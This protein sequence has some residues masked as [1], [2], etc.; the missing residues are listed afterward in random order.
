MTEPPK[1]GPQ[2]GAVMRS[3]WVSAGCV[4]LALGA[5][6]VVLPLLPTTPLVLLAAFCFARGSPR[7]R[8]RLTRSRVFGPIIADWEAHGAIAPRYKAMA[9]GAM[10][11]VLLGSLFAG[12]DWKLIAV[13]ILCMGG[14]AAYVLSRPSWPGR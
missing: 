5:F 14:A 2:A 1:E 4:A 9:C 8:A 3:L 13:Q 7:L 11:L 10:A 12:L 6:G